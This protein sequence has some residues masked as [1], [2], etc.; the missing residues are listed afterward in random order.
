MVVYL[1]DKRVMFVQVAK[2]C[3]PEHNEHNN[4]RTCRSIE[5]GINE[6]RCTSRCKIIKF[7]T[8]H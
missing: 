8:I 6:G 2:Q 5:N 3:V 4:I 1:K 7:N